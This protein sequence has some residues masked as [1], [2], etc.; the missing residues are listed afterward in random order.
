MASGIY[1]LSF[2]SSDKKYIG[3]AVD[4]AKRKRE[5]KA[6]LTNGNHPN[7]HLQRAF[8]KYGE[9]EY[10]F[11]VVLICDRGNCIMYEQ[12]VMDSMAERLYNIAPKAGSQLGMKQSEETRKKI[13]DGLTGRHWKM[14]EEACETNRFV[15]TGRKA[16]DATKAKMSASRTGYKP[17][18]EACRNMVES[19][20]KRAP[21]SDEARAHLS[22]SH[23]GN[24]A[25]DETRRKM[26]EA[27]KNMTQETR[28]KL[29]AATKAYWE[30]KHTEVHCGR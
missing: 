1:Q 27:H 6:F 28:D 26:I 3:S 20:K 16:T 10:R 30:R 13:S 14:S 5:H 24:K 17:T 23:K 15:H 21:V 25:S 7:V 8:N 19:W 2:S 18:E 4:L 22:E 29:S 9:A 11:D 12:T